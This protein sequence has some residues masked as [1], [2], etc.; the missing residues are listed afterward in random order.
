MTPATGFTTRR[1]SPAPNNIA[2]IAAPSSNRCAAP[3][4]H[5]LVTDRI[6]MRRFSGEGRSIC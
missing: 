3:L 4:N 1:Q 5:R 2:P 6:R